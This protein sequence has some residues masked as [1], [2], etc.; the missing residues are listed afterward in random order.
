LCWAKKT[1]ISPSSF[2]S[3]CSSVSGLPHTSFI[4]CDSSA[5]RWERGTF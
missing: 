4:R 2:V 1:L 5:W 3:I